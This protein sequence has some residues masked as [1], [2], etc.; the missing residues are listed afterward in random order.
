ML[1]FYKAKVNAATIEGNIGT[2]GVSTGLCLPHHNFSHDSVGSVLIENADL[3]PEE[4][5]LLEGK[6]QMRVYYGGVIDRWSG[7]PTRQE[8]ESLKFDDLHRRPDYVDVN[9]FSHRNKIP[10]IQ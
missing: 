8:W 3:A 1:A 6:N 7:T 4:A 2:V 5:K 9:R 10:D